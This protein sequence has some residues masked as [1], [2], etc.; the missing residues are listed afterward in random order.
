MRD[1]SD[2]MRINDRW[3]SLTDR[4]PGAR[5]RREEGQAL[6]EFALV[7]PLVLLI[8]FAIIQFGLMLNTYVTVSDAA[9]SGARQL[10]LEQGINDPCDPA[11]KVATTA[12][13]AIGLTPTNVTIGFTSATGTTVGT[14]TTYS[15]T[16][17]YCA[18]V[19]NSTTP[20]T[21]AYPENN[22]TTTNAGSLTE[23]DTASMTVQKIFKPEVLG[24]G[25]FT[26]TLSS[27]ASD[28]VE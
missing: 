5:R 10:A 13:S 11:V 9:R 21:Y 4:I 19:A 1:R 23:G 3:R 17:D 15:T 20:T 25:F 8:L 24:F 22:T 7:L 16:A 28:A 27:T 2:K 6:V 26:V 12:G 18:S 14:T